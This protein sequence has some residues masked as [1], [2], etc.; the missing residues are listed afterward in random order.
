MKKNSL[1]IS[2]QAASAASIST[3]TAIKAVI[4]FLLGETFAWAIV[5]F[6]GV[7][8]IYATIA[9][10]SVVQWFAIVGLLAFARVMF[11]MMFDIL[12]GDE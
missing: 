4:S 7:A 6:C 5:G 8:I 1:A 3:I 2:S 10:S 11:S 9:E 12:T